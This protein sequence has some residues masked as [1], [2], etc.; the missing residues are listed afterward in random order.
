MA[1]VVLKGKHVYML[2]GKNGTVGVNHSNKAFVVGFKDKN[3]ATT[4][5]TMLHEFPQLSL[6][7]NRLENVAEDINN[8]LIGMGLSNIAVSDVVIDTEA[9]LYI[10]KKKQD[11]SQNDIIVEH[12]PF[13][14]FLMY[15]FYKNIGILLPDDILDSN[16][17]YYMFS[18]H[19]VAPSDM[20]GMFRS[21]LKF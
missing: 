18:C 10:T 17:D 4:V 16:E 7:C 9:I 21:S 15:P 8:G 11:E 1:S 20:P 14:D 19:L 12:C 13:E 5:S 2:K 6:Q 3:I